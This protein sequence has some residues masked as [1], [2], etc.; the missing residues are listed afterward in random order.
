MVQQVLVS[1]TTTALGR[2]RLNLLR[3]ASAP[4]VYPL[5]LNYRILVLACSGGSMQDVTVEGNV[6]AYA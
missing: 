4:A 2:A 1:L 3:H 5:Q 6:L